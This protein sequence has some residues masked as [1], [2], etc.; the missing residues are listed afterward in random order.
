MPS[1]RSNRAAAAIDREHDRADRAAGRRIVCPLLAVWSARGPL[2]SWY[3]EESGPLALWQGWG[4]DVRGVA[5][6]GGH[7]FPEEAPEET[8][9]VLDSF[10]R[11]SIPV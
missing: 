10:F 11:G 1:V 5:L 7:F 2:A 6:D 3:V 8:A 9:A 4:E